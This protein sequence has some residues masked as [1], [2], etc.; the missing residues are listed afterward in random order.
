MALGEASPMTFYSPI[1]PEITWEFLVDYAVDAMIRDKRWRPQFV[2][3]QF[4]RHAS[5]TFGWAGLEGALWDLAVQEEGTSFLE[6]LELEPRPLEC[7]LILST[8]PSIRDLERACHRWMKSGYKRIKIKIEPGW[9]IE[10][11]KAVRAEFPDVPIVVDANCSY[12]AEHFEIF[13]ELDKMGLAFIEQPLARND[14]NAH[15][16][17]QQRLQTPICFD[18]SAA[19][20]QR[21]ESAIAMDACRIVNIKTQRVG[22]IMAARRMI[23]RCAAQDIPTWVGTMPELGIGALHGLYLAMH[24]QCTMPTEIEASSRWFIDDIIDPPLTVNDG[25]IEIPEA[26]HRR[27]QVNMD[28]IDRYTRNAKSIKF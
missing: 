15:K 28:V 3:D 25:I 21:L 17:L 11:I 7:G 2:A 9:D 26:H 14:F 27:P 13:D 4:A 8:Y 18:E 6:R 22:G 23:E 16:Q 20:W 5:Q 1:T 12:G 10:P 19:E 24:E